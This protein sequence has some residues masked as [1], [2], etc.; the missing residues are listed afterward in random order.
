[1]PI[2]KNGQ[3]AE[4]PWTN[5]ADEDAVPANGAVI[6]SL[7]RFKAEREALLERRSPL[8]VRLKSEELAKEIS[9]DASHFAL[10]VVELPYFKDGRAF[11]TARLLR[12]RY[13]Y[14]GEIRATGHILPDQAFFLARCGVNS[15]EVKPQTRLEPFA[16]AFREYT[17]GYQSPRSARGTA[18]RLRLRPSAFA[19]AQAAE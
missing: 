9:A 19:Q 8:G 6:V 13:G 14:K 17:V 10:I 5:L 16:D 3:W 4:N 7:K 2:I 1:M 15:I 11:S 12:E 18:P